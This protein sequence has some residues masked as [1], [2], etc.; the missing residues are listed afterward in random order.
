[1]DLV[2]EA[3]PPIVLS[4]E[5]FHRS[6]ARPARELTRWLARTRGSLSP[7][8]VRSAEATAGRLGQRVT[9][10]TGP[11]AIAGDAIRTAAMAGAAAS[12]LLVVG[13][14]LALIAAET[15][16]ADETLVAIGA[17]P[18]ERRGLAAARAVVLTLV[19]GML[20]VPAG[21][22]PIWAWP[23][24]RKR[25]VR[26]TWRFR[27]TRSCSPSWPCR[28][29]LQGQPGCAPGRPGRRWPTDRPDVACRLSRNSPYP[30]ASSPSGPMRRAHVIAR[31]TQRERGRVDIAPAGAASASCLVCHGGTRERPRDLTDDTDQAS[32]VGRPTGARPEGD[33]GGAEVQPGT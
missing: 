3:V 1:M 23:R 33:L 17:P 24:P 18:R 28:L 5:T 30:D 6:G 4:T 10:E 7:V 8:Q 13:I 31:T 32:L 20:A 25:A 2:P 21:L 15:R 29:S 11:P 9:V 27:G 16:S 12:S 14:G 22:L 19:G 26:H